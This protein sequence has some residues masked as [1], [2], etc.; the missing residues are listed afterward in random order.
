[1]LDWVCSSLGILERDYFGLL[2]WSDKA[3]MVGVAVHTYEVVKQLRT[4]FTCMR[5]YMHYFSGIHCTFRM[6]YV[7]DHVFQNLLY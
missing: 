1:M 6:Y 4:C 5:I 7:L 3:Q 2:F